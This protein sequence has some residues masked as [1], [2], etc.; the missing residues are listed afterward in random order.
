MPYRL[1]RPIRVSLQR[2]SLS[3]RTIFVSFNS[4]CQIGSTASLA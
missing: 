3:T 4:V 1:P 2:D